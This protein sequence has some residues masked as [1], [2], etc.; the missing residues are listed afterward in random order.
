MEWRDEGLIIG[1]RKHGETS[2]ILEVMTR[3]H[4]RHLGL[5]KGGRAKRMQ[6]V[7]QPGNHVDVVWRARLDEHLGLFAVEATDLRTA[8]LMTNPEAL[9]C[10]NLV[11]ALLRLVA[12]RDPHPGLYEA[13]RLIVDHLEEQHIAPPLLVRF[14]LAILTESGFGLDLSSCAATGVS[15]DLVYVSPKSGRA[16]S[17]GAGAPYR[18]R[19]LALPP[20]LLADEVCDAPSAEDVRDGFRLT[21]YFLRRDVFGPRGLPLPLAREAYLNAVAKRS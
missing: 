20:F 1:L 12:E 8:R 5:V 18:D 7:L 14:E 9:H 11:A 3:G 10:V 15:D 13:A 16:V 2:V 19:L 6:P 17:R 21:E 4:G